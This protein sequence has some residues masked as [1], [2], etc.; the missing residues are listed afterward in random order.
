M[1]WREK[2]VIK[3]LY[4]RSRDALLCWYVGLQIPS[5]SAGNLQTNMRPHRSNPGEGLLGVRI[6]GQIC[7][8]STKS[9]LLTEIEAPHDNPGWDI[10]FLRRKLKLSIALTGAP[11][12]FL[13]EGIFPSPK[14]DVISYTPLKFLLYSTVTIIIY[15][16]RFLVLFCI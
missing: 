12:H 4:Q 14:M 16:N 10:I 1:G 6:F 8:I 15:T 11:V 7:L 2:F 13:R 9:A 5:R 3:C